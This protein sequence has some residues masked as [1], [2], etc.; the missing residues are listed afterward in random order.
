MTT[1]WRRWLSGTNAVKPKY[2]YMENLNWCT[3]NTDMENFATWIMASTHFNF[4][5]YNTSHGR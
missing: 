3:I 1:E 4:Q 2:M 5:K